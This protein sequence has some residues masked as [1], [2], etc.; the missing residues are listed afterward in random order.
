MNEPGLPIY[1][2]SIRCHFQNEYESI[3]KSGAA[4]LR[5]YKIGANAIRPY[6]NK[7]INELMVVFILCVLCVSWFM[8]F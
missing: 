1:S 4:A 6:K 8:I 5:P 3:Q 7:M 2:F